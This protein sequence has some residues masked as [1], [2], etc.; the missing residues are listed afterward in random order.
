MGYV[1]NIIEQISGFFFFNQV[2]LLNLSNLNRQ[3][4]IEIITIQSIL[5]LCSTQKWHMFTPTN[6]FY[7]HP[8]TLYYTNIAMGGETGKKK[9]KR[10]Q[11][12]CSI[13]PSSPMK[14]LLV[15]VFTSSALS[16]FS[17]GT[18]LAVVEPGPQQPLSANS[19]LLQR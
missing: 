19:K 2:Y 17:H 13:H 3:S 7:C 1:Q 14:D 10:H 15:N 9:K 5:K 6:I 16:I 8:K 11:G 18:R 12:C 4:E